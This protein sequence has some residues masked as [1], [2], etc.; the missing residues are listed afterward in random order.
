MK[1][2]RRELNMQEGWLKRTFIAKMTSG[3][4]VRVESTRICSM[5]RTKVGA[6]AYQVTPLNFSGSAAITAFVDFDVMNA[7]SNYDEKFWIEREKNADLEFS[8]VM[9][10]TKK[11]DF[12]VATGMEFN[13][14]GAWESGKRTALE[15]EK[16]VE[17]TETGMFQKDK[18][19][20]YLNMLQT[21][22]PCTL[23]RVNWLMFV[24]KRCLLPLKQGL[25]LLLMNIKRLG[26]RNGR[27]QI[28]SL[29]AMFLLNREFDSIFFN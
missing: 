12:W 23:K 8:Y 16:Y 1:E 3:K 28:W 25:M 6:I 21:S 20:P 15:K 26:Y 19:S 29:M 24:E 5:A 13:I 4:E 17:V 7:D 27:N 2:F 18:T 11:T 10:S 22:L 14:A 9:A